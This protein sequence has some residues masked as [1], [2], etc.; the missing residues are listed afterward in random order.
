MGGPV[1][2]IFG[3]VPHQRLVNDT[4]QQEKPS[5]VKILFL[6]QKA[7]NMLRGVQQELHVGSYRL[8]YAQLC[9]LLT[10]GVVNASDCKYRK[11]MLTINF[12]G[13]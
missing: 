13:N 11:Y 12:S 1:I 5:C 7:P 6:L 10:A 3:V 2:L 9:I 8:Q 4:G